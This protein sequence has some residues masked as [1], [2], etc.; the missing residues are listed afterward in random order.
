MVKPRRLCLSARACVRWRSIAPRVYDW[1]ILLRKRVPVFFQCTP[2]RGRRSGPLPQS[3]AALSVVVDVLDAN[4][5]LM[6][7]MAGATGVGFPVPRP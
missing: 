5:G 6:P 1:H 4:G 7:A 3:G 2:A